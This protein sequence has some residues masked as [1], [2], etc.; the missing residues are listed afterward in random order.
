MTARGGGSGKSGGQVR[1]EAE[2]WW[3][4]RRGGGGEHLREGTSDAQDAWLRWSSAS[5]S[6]K[7]P[8]RIAHIIPGNILEGGGDSWT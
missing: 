1:R 7:K 6:S 8:F 3:A 4:G 5:N 2:V